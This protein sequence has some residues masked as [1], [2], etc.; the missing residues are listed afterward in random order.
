M[1]FCLPTGQE[2]WYSRFEHLRP[3]NV[4]LVLRSPVPLQPDAGTK[5]YVVVVGIFPDKLLRYSRGDFPW[6]FTEVGAV[7]YQREKMMAERRLSKFKRRACGGV[8]S[9]MSVEDDEKKLLCE[10]FGGDIFGK[11]CLRYF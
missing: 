1:Y 9:L 3:L 8:Y 2:H 6:L 11:G 4:I 10:L 7:K 5:C